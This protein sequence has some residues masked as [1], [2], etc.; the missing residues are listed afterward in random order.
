MNRYAID[1]ARTVLVNF[2][3]L[4]LEGEVPTGPADAEDYRRVAAALT[5]APQF[6]ASTVADWDESER[7]ALFEMLAGAI[8]E[9]RSPARGE[10]EPDTLEDSAPSAIGARFARWLVAKHEEA[11]MTALLHRLSARR[12]PSPTAW[13]V[14]V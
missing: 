12:R 5:A 2:T 8:V 6:L 10:F 9:L 1:T 3:R 7:R 14:R 4:A 13:S 11:R